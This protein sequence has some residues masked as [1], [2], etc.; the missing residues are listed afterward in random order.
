MGVRC[1]IVWYGDEKVSRGTSIPFSYSYIT[2][3]FMVRKSIIE[4]WRERDES[5]VLHR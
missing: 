4:I 5:R 1:K 3:S 2:E